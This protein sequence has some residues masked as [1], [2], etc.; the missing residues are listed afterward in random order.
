[1]RRCFLAA[2][3]FA[4]VARGATTI[5]VSNEV[6]VPGVKRFGLDLAQV[7]YYDSGQMMKELVFRNPGFEGLLFQS[8]VRV[9]SG[10]TTNAIEDGPYTQWPSGFWDGAKYEFIW[11]TAHGRTGVV[12]R[13]LAPN[14]TN[15]PNDPNGSTNGTTYV[16]AD[17]GAAPIPGDY[18]VLRKSEIGD[19]GGGPA[20]SGW[21]LNLT[22]GATATTELADLHPA[23]LGKQCIRLTSTNVG[24]NVTLTGN[25]DTWNGVNFVRLNGGFRL[26]FKAKG[27]GGANRLLVTLRRGAGSYWI[28]ST[29]QLS[30]VWQ[31]Y[32]NTFTA[33]EGTNISG[34]VSLQFMPVNQSAAL[35][36]DVSLR[37][38]DGDPTNTSEFRDPVVAAIR[39]LRPGFL[40]YPNWQM[41]G[42]SL[43]NALAPPFAR[44]RNDYSSYHTSSGNILLGLHEFLDLCQ[45]VGADPWFTTP[46]IYSAREMQN[47]ME[48]LGGAI[49]TA[50]GAVRAAKGHP[51][52]WTDAFA[53]IHIEFGN[54]SW[55][56]GYRGGNIGDTVAYGNRGSEL[57]G[58]AKA[59][60]HYSAGRFNFI[61]GEQWVV[62]WRVIRTHN[63]SANHDTMT[64]AGYMASR[65]DSYATDE[66]LFGSVLA[67]PEWWSTRDGLLYQDYTNLLYSS[68]PV[69]ISVYEVNINAPGGAITN[70]QAA[71]T[72]YTPSLGAGLAVADHMMMMLRELRARE[73]GLFALPGYEFQSGTNRALVW[74][75]VRDM[76]VTDRRRPTYLACQ[77]MNEV[78]AG[79]MLRTDHAGDNPTWSVSNVNNVTYSN[80]HYIQSY[81][82]SNGAS[83]AMIVFNLHRTDPLQVDFAGPNAPMGAVAWKVLGAPAITNNNENSVSVTISEQQLPDH[84]PA[85]AIVLAPHSMN[86]FQWTA[87]TSL[88][89]WRHANFG[90]T[91]GVGAAADVADPE[92]DGLPNLV[93]YGLGSDPLARGPGGGPGFA[94][95]EISGARYLMIA[96]PKNPDAVDLVYV[97]QVSDDLVRWHEGPAHT[98]VLVDTA[99]QIQARDNT[100]LSDAGRRFIRLSISHP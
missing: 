10:T 15:P 29:T 54:E 85:Q 37:Q 95:M 46:I 44:A 91:L 3:F 4:G 61:L 36:D 17:A 77:L 42:D 31:T 62:P 94:V 66:Q 39:T 90:T 8:V 64:V 72:A 87:P 9:A 2:V 13:S 34:A 35:I 69:P 78:L 6:A 92:G 21:W 68:R 93:E 18:L 82:F 89:R 97:P 47:L 25:F 48:Y 38:T 11:G 55:N 88:Q 33:A 20:S 100:P 12:A 83:R 63:A 26:V 58:V 65:I 51:A 76:G 67:E 73:Q 22:N 98:T 53:R 96:A 28:N 5:V 45:L 84:D 86:V 56:G 52:P 50:Y 49:S 16:L 32:T 7:N 23:T 24:Q 57:F 59:S 60:P 70:S 74:S 40:R 30:D 71:L 43:D 99:T 75:I 1:M 27:A 79:D 80:A 14:R 41:L 19:V 81:A